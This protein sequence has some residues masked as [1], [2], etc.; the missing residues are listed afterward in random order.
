MKRQKGRKQE[1]RKV[2]ALIVDGKD[3]K[4][5]ME[6]V[7]EYYHDGKLKSLTYIIHRGR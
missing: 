2:I 7:R 3:E 4:W 6:K 1:P 5:Y